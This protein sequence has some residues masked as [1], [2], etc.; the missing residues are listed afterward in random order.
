[1]DGLTKPLKQLLR[2]VQE[3]NETVFDVVKDIMSDG[4]PKTVLTITNRRVNPEPPEQPKLAISPKRAHAFH[5]AT[6][7]MV[8]LAKYKTAHTVVLADAVNGWVSA[9]LDEGAEYGFEVLT[10]SPKEHPLFTPW[11]SMLSKWMPLRTAIDFL[12]DNRRCISDPDGKQ[13]ARD[14][15]QIKISQKVERMQG[16]GTK[17]IN[18]VMVETNI[19]GAKKASPME[20]PEDI[21]INVP[22][23]VGC[24]PV[25]MTFDVSIDSHEEHGVLIRFSSPDINAKRAQ[26]FDQFV[27]QIQTGLGSEVVVGLGSIDHDD[28]KVLH[29]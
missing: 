14:L 5:D 24:Q 2:D 8:Y 13:L 22:M 11:L 4:T 28:W 9:V 29:A 1:M 25:D 15:S 20:L 7:F 18:G 3:G 17:S 23:Y 26:Q 12:L 16:L 21:T 19:G 6:S 27:R 10:F